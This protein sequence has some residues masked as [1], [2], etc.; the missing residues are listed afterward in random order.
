[1]IVDVAQPILLV[2]E[3]NKVE[4]AVTR[5]SR[6]G[7]DQVLGHLEGGIDAWQAA[8]RKSMPSRRCRPLNLLTG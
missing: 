8:A 5:L 7:F 2:C 6:V 4:E 1:M 3:A